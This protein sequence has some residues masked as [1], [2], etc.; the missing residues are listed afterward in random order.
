MLRTS[1]SYGLESRTT[2]SERPLRLPVAPFPGQASAGYLT[3]DSG[4]MCGP[5][6]LLAE[7]Y[8]FLKPPIKKWTAAL[9]P[10][11]AGPP[12]VFTG[13]LTPLFP[14]SSVWRPHLTLH[15]LV[16]H[17]IWLFLSTSGVKHLNSAD[18]CVS[19]LIQAVPGRGNTNRNPMQLLPVSSL[20]FKVSYC[21]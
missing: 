14:C 10:F 1:R 15:L 13:R 19:S 7:K 8:C 12:P 5:E 2:C 18:T 16:T 11:L 3:L 17:E 4:K 6:R 20:Q 21:P 9:G